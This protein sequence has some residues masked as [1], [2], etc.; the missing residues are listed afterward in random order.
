MNDGSV[1]HNPNDILQRWKEEYSK[2]FS[3]EVTNADSEFIERLHSLNTELECE[4]NDLGFNNESADANPDI[5]DMNDPI[6]LE[7]TKGALMKL[8]NGKAVGIHDLPNEILKNDHLSNAVKEL[9]RVCFSHSIVPD[10]WCQRIICPL[11]KKTKTFA[12][13]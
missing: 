12:I 11:L 6:T 9:F 5:S 4:Y 10:A 7:E 13:H 2:L 1:S 8:K 3:S